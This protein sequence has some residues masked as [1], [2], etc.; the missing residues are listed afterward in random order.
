[1]N[2][3]SGMLYVFV[4]DVLLQWEGTSS[5]AALCAEGTST[6]AKDAVVDLNVDTSRLYIHCIHIR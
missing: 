3:I 5:T 6:A 4:I 1:M 2:K